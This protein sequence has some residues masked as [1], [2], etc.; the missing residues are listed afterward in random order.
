MKAAPLTNGSGA[1][2]G[3]AGSAAQ[4]HTGAWDGDFAAKTRSMSSRNLFGQAVGSISLGRQVLSKK[5][6]SG[7]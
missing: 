3:L 5:G 2:F 6:W 7:L 4:I 1:R